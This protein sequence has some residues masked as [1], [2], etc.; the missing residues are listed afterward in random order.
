MQIFKYLFTIISVISR[1][2]IIKIYCDI[3]VEHLLETELSIVVMVSYVNL[4]TTMSQQFN[5]Y[6]F[7]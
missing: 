5:T 3:S 4:S 6:L 2:T 7:L 1:N